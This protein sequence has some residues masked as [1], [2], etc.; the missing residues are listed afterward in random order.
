[1]RTPLLALRL[2]FCVRVSSYH[3]TRQTLQPQV[4]PRSALWPF[5]QR[6]PSTGNRKEA[7]GQPPKPQ[8]SWPPA[9]TTLAFD[10]CRTTPSRVLLTSTISTLVLHHGPVRI[11]SCRH[12]APLRS[13]TKCLGPLRIR[14][15]FLPVFRHTQGHFGMYPFSLRIQTGNHIALKRLAMM[16]FHRGRP[17]TMPTQIQPPLFHNQAR[18]V[19]ARLR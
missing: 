12:L 4:D 7:R 8:A 5:A 15:T 9:R 10:T 17:N 1:M 2:D 6:E 11:T 18:A 3:P 19:R 14:T 16:A 13:C